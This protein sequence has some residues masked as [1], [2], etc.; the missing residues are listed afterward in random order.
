M[1]L[2]MVTREAGGVTVM[3]DAGGAMGVT[4]TV[5]EAGQV[6]PVARAVTVTVEGTAALPE[7]VIVAV[8]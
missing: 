5:A 3:V 6:E 1:T 4:V 7:A 8:T 2:V